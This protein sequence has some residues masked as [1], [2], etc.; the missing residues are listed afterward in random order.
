MKNYLIAT[1][2][3]FYCEDLI[4]GESTKIISDN[5]TAAGFELVDD[6][7]EAMWNPDNESINKCVEYW[8]LFAGKASI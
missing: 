6:G 2:R 7:T 5:L 3:I 1:N 8:K 4:S